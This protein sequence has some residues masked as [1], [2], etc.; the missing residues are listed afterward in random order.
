MHF[1]FKR[2]LEQVVVEQEG[3]IMIKQE[4]NPLEQV[5]DLVLMYLIKFIL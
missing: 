2:E 4:E 1:M 3:L 5:V